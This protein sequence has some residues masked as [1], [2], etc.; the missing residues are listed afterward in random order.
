MLALLRLPPFTA[1][2]TSGFARRNRSIT[3]QSASV[4]ANAYDRC[5]VGGL[6]HSRGTAARCYCVPCTC[7]YHL[8]P[9]RDTQRTHTG[10]TRRLAGRSPLVRK[11]P[12]VETLAPAGVICTEKTGT[13]TEGDRKSI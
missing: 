5:F 1:S 4:V 9:P 7:K 6:R 10:A 12:A 13:L 11:L 2:R 3:L 8:G